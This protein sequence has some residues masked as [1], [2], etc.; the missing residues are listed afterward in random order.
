MAT[1]RV[2]ASVG[3]AWTDISGA[4]AAVAGVTWQNVGKDRAVLAFTAVA[5]VAAD[6]FLT[7]EPGQ[8]FYDK[9]GSANIWAKSAGPAG[10]IL[11]GVSD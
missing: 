6:P 2:L 11:S 1:G 4:A 5:P 9:T 3:T 10:S 8:M 7:L